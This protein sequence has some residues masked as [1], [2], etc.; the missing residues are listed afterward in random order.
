MQRSSRLRLKFP[1]KPSEQKEELQAFGIKCVCRVEN[2][3]ELQPVEL[4]TPFGE[5]SEEDLLP[6][7]EFPFSERSKIEE[8]EHPQSPSFTS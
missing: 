5:V 7:G 8:V 2:L 4:F 6:G 3:D 1:T